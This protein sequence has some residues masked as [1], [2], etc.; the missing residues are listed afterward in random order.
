MGYLWVTSMGDEEKQGDGKM[1]LV[2]IIMGLFLINVPK[3]IY[4]I[5][6][7]S[8]YLDS[9]FRKVQSISTGDPGGELSES[10]L[11][12]CNYFFCP[13]NFW[14]NGSTVAVIKFFEILMLVTA[15]VMF[16]WGGLTLIFRGHDEAYTKTAKMRLIYGMIAL[17]VVGFLDTIYRAVFF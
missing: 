17:I 10:A 9:D 3:V 12:T 15:V 8:N 16:S 6:T 5:L 11:D 1:R 13:Q 2:L 4:T 7:G 14:G